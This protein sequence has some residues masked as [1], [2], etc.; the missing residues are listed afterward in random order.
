MQFK[1][2]NNRYKAIKMKP[3]KNTGFEINTSS[4]YTSKF[5]LQNILKA[6]QQTAHTEY[7]IQMSIKLK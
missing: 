1:R 2:K 4:P 6:S 3:R 5:Q 7:K